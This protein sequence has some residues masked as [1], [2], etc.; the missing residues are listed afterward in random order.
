MLDI[1][2]FFEKLYNKS[3]FEARCRPRKR[4]L[5]S[6]NE[7]F[8]AKPDAERALF[9]IFF[10]INYSFDILAIIVSMINERRSPMP[11]HIQVHATHTASNCSEGLYV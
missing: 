1:L 8:E 9:D 11:V 7:H 3:Y 5:L 10:I 4:S 2:L 6:V